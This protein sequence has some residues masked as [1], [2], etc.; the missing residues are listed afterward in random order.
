MARSRCSASTGTRATDLWAVFGAA[1]FA[2]RLLCG[3]GG[4]G[5]TG[6]GATDAGDG[7]RLVCVVRCAG[8]GWLR[9]G[10]AVGMWGPRA[11]GLPRSTAPEGGPMR[12]EWPR[13]RKAWLYTH[14]SLTAV[15]EAGLPDGLVRGGDEVIGT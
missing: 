12:R 9:E 14:A 1:G 2:V 8:A 11:G 5:G 10:A 13:P 6:L 15:R 3:F 4:I 7:A